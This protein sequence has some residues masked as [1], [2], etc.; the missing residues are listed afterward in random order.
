MEAVRAALLLVDVAPDR[1][2]I[3]ALAAVFRAPLWEWLSCDAVVWLFGPT[4][5]LKSS[6]AALLLGFYGTS[7][8]RERSHRELDGYRRVA[9]ETKLFR[10]KD[11]SSS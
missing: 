7:F 9:Q 10:A 8:D 5:A 6:L 11:V 3:P 2:T 1:V 4:G